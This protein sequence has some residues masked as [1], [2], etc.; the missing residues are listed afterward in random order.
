MVIEKKTLLSFKTWSTPSQILPLCICKDRRWRTLFTT[1]QALVVGEVRT[2]SRASM[3]AH[4]LL[5]TV[6]FQPM[7]TIKREGQF[8]L[9]YSSDFLFSCFVFNFFCVFNKL[10]FELAY[11]KNAFTNQLSSWWCDTS[12]QL[13]ICVS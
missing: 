13:W 6:Y 9:V 4:H 5:K 11:P 12:N 10:F 7:K 2:E 8:G 1:K 3:H